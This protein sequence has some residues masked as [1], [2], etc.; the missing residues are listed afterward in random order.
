MDGRFL[1]E[2]SQLSRTHKK[3][4]LPLDSCDSWRVL[5][6]MS[7]YGIR[8]RH[9]PKSRFKIIKC[10]QV[11]SQPHCE[12]CE[13]DNSPY[14]FH[15]HER[16]FAERSCEVTTASAGP[17]LAP[18]PRSSSQGTE[19]SGVS[20]ARRNSVDAPLWYWGPQ[21]SLDHEHAS[22]I[23][24]SSPL[25]DLFSSPQPSNQDQWSS[26]SLIGSAWPHYERWVYV[27]PSVR[28]KSSDA[29]AHSGRQHS[30]MSSSHHLGIGGLRGWNCMFNH[31]LPPSNSC[32]VNIPTLTLPV[33]RQ[34]GPQSPTYLANDP[35]TFFLPG[36]S[37]GLEAASS[38]VQRDAPNS[39]ADP[40][41]AITQ[42]IVGAVLSLR[43]DQWPTA[44][45]VYFD[46]PPDTHEYS[47]HFPR[48]PTQ[49]NADSPAITVEM[50]SVSPHLQSPSLGPH[51]VAS[52]LS[53]SP[54]FLGSLADIFTV[55]SQ[56]LRDVA[57]T[58]SETS[59]E[60]LSR[61]VET[62]PES[63]TIQ[64]ER[65]TDVTVAAKANFC[66]PCRVSFTQPQVFRRHLKDKHKEKESCTHC[67]RFTWSQGRPYL[68]RR[69]LR[70]KHPEVTS[71]EVRLRRPRKSR[72]V[73]ARQ[74]NI[75]NITTEVP[76]GG[77]FPQLCHPC[78]DRISGPSIPSPC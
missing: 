45:R 60:V 52:H 46:G 63:V 73:G 22:P 3:C 25:Y 7:R 76:F 21:A 44:E 29:H 37:S 51:I 9:I 49:C 71:S 23:A 78:H 8:C 36:L 62:Y 14:R 33:H 61:S 34:D 50:A 16:Y 56:Q 40:H 19:L 30:H 5:G 35:K 48:M 70:L 20:P 18:S 64:Q 32:Q 74:H 69:H 54:S 43:G 38:S 1:L 12:A 39:N 11:K 67:S 17:S 13:T 15:E 27:R 72:I 26:T 31:T 6:H 68:Y 59:P 65:T 77:V 28:F 24:S 2:A 53:L 4:P 75:P 41:G 42:P 47:T 10:E 58:E 57:T 55:D 66:H